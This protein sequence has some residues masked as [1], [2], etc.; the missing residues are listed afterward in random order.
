MTVKTE[1]FY[2]GEMKEYEVPVKT[3]DSISS[4]VG[5]GN[6]TLILKMEDGYIFIDLAG[7]G[8]KDLVA[9]KYI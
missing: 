9:I 4:E 1:L 2:C 7:S 5:N 3:W 8:N 6:N